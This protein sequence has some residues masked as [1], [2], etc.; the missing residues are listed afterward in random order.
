LNIFDKR[1]IKY[2]IEIKKIDEGLKKK[3]I[4]QFKKIRY[5][6]YDEVFSKY[7]EYSTEYCLKKTFDVL[8]IEYDD[9]LIHKCAGVLHVIEGDFWKPFPSTE[10]TLKELKKNGIKIAL[11]SNAPYD[12]GIKT[13]L[14]A[15]NLIQYFDL[16][17]TSANIG[18]AKPNPITFQT[19]LKQ[20]NVKPE[21]AVMVGDDLLNDCKG[22]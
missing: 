22:K 16:I 8:N 20:L 14:K 1:K 13:L 3:L 5:K 10:K 9:E 12:K 7:V 19:V 4:R 21:E 15:H 18:Y 6:T 11:L 2:L 17:E